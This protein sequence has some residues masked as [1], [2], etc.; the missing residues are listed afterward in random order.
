[1]HKE[2]RQKKEEPVKAESGGAR[3]RAPAENT[4]DVWDEKSAKT[5]SVDQN[6]TLT[7]IGGER[8]AFP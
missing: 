2:K 3:P 6:D 4:S 1:L 8:E 5:V 7:S